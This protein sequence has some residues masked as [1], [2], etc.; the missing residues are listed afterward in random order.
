MIKLELNLNDICL[1]FVFYAN[2]KIEK[3]HK[4]EIAQANI[5]ELLTKLNIDIFLILQIHTCSKLEQF[6]KVF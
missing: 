1:A 6:R 3:V 4:F 5:E 2:Q